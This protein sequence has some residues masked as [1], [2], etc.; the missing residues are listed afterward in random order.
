MTSLYFGLLPS[1]QR[2]HFFSYFQH[3]QSVC[4]SYFQHCLFSLKLSRY[5]AIGSLKAIVHA[6]FPN[7]Y[8]TSSTDLLVSMKEEMSQIGCHKKKEEPIKT[9]FEKE[10][11]IIDDSLE[12]K[13][14]LNF[15]NVFVDPTTAE[16]IIE[17]KRAN[18]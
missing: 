11:I 18:N 7:L 10:S 6:F 9:I 13:N 16:L 5:F 4:M 12:E 3:P 2:K 8:I 17:Q 15:E 14:E 1:Y